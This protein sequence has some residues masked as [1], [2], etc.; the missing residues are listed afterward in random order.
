MTR[1]WPR[2]LL[3]L[4]RILGILF[5]LFLGLFAFDVFGMEGSIWERIGAFLI[6]LIPTYLVLIAVALG[7][8]W[9]WLGGLL[10][11]ALAALYLV[12]SLGQGMANVIIA[13]PA[14]VTGLLFLT[15]WAAGRT[16]PPGN[17]GSSL[18]PD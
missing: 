1:T 18:Q 2:N 8:R 10:F 9:P 4:A 16:A 11:L 14:V 17:D 15:G 12:L 5:A 3:W 7:W 6:H 13:G